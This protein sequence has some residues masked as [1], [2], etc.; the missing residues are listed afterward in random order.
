VLVAAARDGRIT[1]LCAQCPSLGNREAVK[2]Q[3]KRLGFGYVLRLLVHGQPDMVRSWLSLS[4]HKIP[5]TAPKGSI[6]LLSDDQAFQAFSRMTPADY[7]N[8]AC[9][10][11]L[12]RVDKYRPIKFA[13]RVNCPCLLLVCDRDQIVPPD[14][15]EHAAK[16]LGRKAELKHYPIGHFDIYFG[17]YREKSIQDQLD[18]LSRH[19]AAPTPS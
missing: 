12:P 3:I 2:E 19:L 4:P 7:V 8:Q 14:A 5:V 11:I 18:F 13:S 9:A 1:R 15:A 10:R 6:A 17:E 16:A